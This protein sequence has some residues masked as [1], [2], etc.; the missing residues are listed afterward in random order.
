MPC[1]SDVKPRYR[2][3]Y[4]VWWLDK[5]LETLLMVAFPD[6]HE[7]WGRWVHNNATEEELKFHVNLFTEAIELAAKLD[8]LSVEGKFEVRELSRVRWGKFEVGTL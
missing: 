3:E 7:K 1:T 8:G 4:E 2:V 5:E 6:Y